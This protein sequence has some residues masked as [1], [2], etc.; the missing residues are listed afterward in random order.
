M[1]EIKLE[2]LFIIC[3]ADYYDQTWRRRQQVMFRLSQ[4][5]E[6]RRVLYIERP[7]TVISLL[8]YMVGRADKDASHRW[9]RVFNNGFRFVPNQKFIVLTPISLLP[10]GTSLIRGINRWLWCKLIDLIMRQEIARENSKNLPIMWVSVPEGVNFTDSK[11]LAG[12]VYD[13]TENFSAFYDLSPTVR[14]QYKLAQQKLLRVSSLVFV[15]TESMLKEFQNK[16]PKVFLVPNAVDL[17]V[18]NYHGMYS[19]PSDWPAEAMDG[20]PILGYHGSIF[21]RLDVDLLTKVAMS[22]PDWILVLIGSISSTF[23]KI[24]SLVS[25]PSVFCL[26]AKSYNE[27]PAY[28]IR[29][30]VG[31]IPQRVDQLTASQSPLKL[32]EYLAMGKPVVATRIDGVKGLESVV[33][34]ASGPTD[35]IVKIE[36]IL[37]ERP[38]EEQITIRLK[39]AQEH[40]WD[41]I[42]DRMIE[43]VLDVLKN[44]AQE[45]RHI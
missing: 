35:F 16:H 33:R 12:I 44:K 2:K 21:E 9:R 36:D 6:V 17:S 41:C 42:V 15:Q 23:R 22:H 5:V 29:Y 27:L 20:R 3:F 4:R 19:I 39:I 37:R 34:V 24:E 28:L 38:N 31:L 11:E 25:L 13:C 32:F 43:L 7:L 40:S 14:K 8:K 26:G 18:F 10:M 45:R 30:D 1:G